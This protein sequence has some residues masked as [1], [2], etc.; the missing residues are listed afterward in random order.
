LAALALP[1][2]LETPGPEWKTRQQICDELGI[3][4]WAAQSKLAQGVKAGKI[5]FRK[6]LVPGTSGYRHM[7]PH[8]RII[9]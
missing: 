3:T 9:K 1:A 5:E 7:A 2:E 6:F 8:Y 4:R